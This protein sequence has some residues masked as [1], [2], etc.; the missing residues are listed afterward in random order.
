[1]LGFCLA[2]AAI[3]SA[4]YRNRPIFIPDVGREIAPALRRDIFHKLRQALPQLFSTL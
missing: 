1:L 2:G 3:F 4:H